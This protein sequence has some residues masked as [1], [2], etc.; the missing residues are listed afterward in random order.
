MTSPVS[1][2][3]NGLTGK[4]CGVGPPSPKR[5]R[6]VT[7]IVAERRTLAAE[8]RAL[9]A[10]R[11]AAAAEEKANR[12]WEKVFSAEQQAYD[13]EEQASA[14]WLQI[15]EGK[16]QVKEAEQ[17][18]RAAI[19]RAA[20]TVVRERGVDVKKNDE[21]NTTTTCSICMN[22]YKKDEAVLLRCGHGL[23]LGCYHEMSV[24]HNF[25]RCPMCRANI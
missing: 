24:V 11:R 2:A 15:W 6:F 14:A 22:N 7:A 19:R 1:L 20:M 12:A 16:Q 21:D 5:R 13:A 4:D 3:G 10:E 25:T 23:H 8:Q 17:R 9:V 18:A